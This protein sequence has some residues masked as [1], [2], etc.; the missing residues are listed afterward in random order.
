[1]R[2]ASVAKKYL[3]KKRQPKDVRLDINAEAFIRATVAV[4]NNIRWPSASLE[5]MFSWKN[6]VNTSNKLNEMVSGSFK[7]SSLIYGMTNSILPQTNKH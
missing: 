2:T 3:K 6:K 5:T 7:F 1:M 4:W